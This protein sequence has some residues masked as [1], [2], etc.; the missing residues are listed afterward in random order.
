MQKRDKMLIFFL[1]NRYIFVIYSDIYA[2]NCKLEGVTLAIHQ[3][4]VCSVIIRGK[5]RSTNS[6]DTAPFGKQGIV[7]YFWLDTSLGLTQKCMLAENLKVCPHVA[8]CIHKVT[9][10][11]FILH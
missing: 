3:Q 10:G 11:R 1:F 2:S 9:A 5:A 6:C 7:R 4:G 8:I